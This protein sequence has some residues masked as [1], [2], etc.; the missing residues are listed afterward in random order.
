MFGLGTIVNTV[1]IIVAGVLGK[2][3]GK[4][5]KKETAATLQST[6]GV[7]VLFVGI[8]G[9]LE[10]ML[11]VSGTGV[12]AGMSMFIVICLLLGAIVGEL[13]DFE[14]L[15]EKFGIWLRQ[16]TG[17]AKDAQFVDAFLVATFTVCIGAMAIVGAIED[18]INHNYTI[19]FTKSVL[20]FIIVFVMSGS[21][22]KG[23][24]FSFIPVFLFQGL[25]TVLSRFI[26]PI[27]TEQ[28][29]LNLSMI[30]SIL[31][32]CVGI[33]LIWGKKIKVAN[34]LPALIFAVIG[35]FLPFFD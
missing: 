29:T 35:A 2:F 13:I 28:A 20:D 7:A 17:N 33:N 15:F 22:G 25:F 4:L 10:G 1:A 30:G 31:I 6:C 18:G 9:A 21:M 27:M 8:G 23:A 19:L 5:L 3:F 14:G 12:K 24:T 26:Q 32:F 34:L 11:K 16:K